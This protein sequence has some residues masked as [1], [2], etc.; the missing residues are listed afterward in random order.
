MRTLAYCSLPAYLFLLVMP[1]A[2]PLLAG[3]WPAYKAD[4]ARSSVTRDKITFPIQNVWG[5]EPLQAPRP[6]WPEPGKELHRLDF[7]Y[8]P[9]PVIAGGHVYFASSADD[10]VRALDASSGKTKWHFTTAGPVRFAPAVAG[11]KVYVASDDG[12]LYCLD[13]VS[14]KLTW[15]FRGAPDPDQVLGNGRMVSRWPLRG[16]VL[17]DD[18][19][20][21][22]AAGM[23]PSH[24]IYVYALDAVTGKVKWLNDSSGS[25]YID[26]PH[27]GASAFTGVAPQG[28]LLATKDVLMVPTGRSVPA[29]YDR[30]TGRFMYY[31]PAIN[32]RNGGSWATVAGD[33]FFSQKHGG[34]PDIDIQIGESNPRPG[35]GMLA[36]SIAS[37]EKELELPDKHRVIVD[38]DVLYASGGDEIQAIDLKAWREKK[39]LT[40]CIKWSVPLGRTYCLALADTVLLAGGSGSLTAFDTGSGKQ[41]WNWEVDGQVRGLAFAS[42][43]L[44]AAT[45]K[46]RLYGFEHREIAVPA[47]SLK[48]RPSWKVG[49][50]GKQISVAE[51][52]VKSTG[53]TSGYGIVIGETD[54]RLAM[55]LATQTDLQLISVVRGAD[56]A[57]AERNRLLTTGLYGT[58]IVVHDLESPEQLPYSPY[59]ASLVVVTGNADG[60]PGKELYRVLRPCGGVMVFPGLKSSAAK[61][62][63]K[64]AGIPR[65]ETSSSGGWTIVRGKLP[66]AGE[67]RHQW[68]DGG[69][70]GVSDE[71]RVRLPLDVLWFGGPG[72]DRMMSRHWGTSTPLSVD[73][74]VFITGQHHLITID[75]YTGRELWVSE[76]SGAGRKGA[77][78]NSAN[79]VADDDSLYV[80][81]GSSCH[82]LSQATGKTEAVYGTPETLEES[83]A[84][85]PVSQA[86]DVVWPRSWHIVGPL[87]KDSPP[88]DAEQ[89]KTMPKQ[90]AV[91]GKTY[92]AASLESVKGFLDFSNLY[93]G[94]GFAP[95]KPGEK[96]GPYP[97]PGMRRD[98]DS[99]GR[100]LYA[101]ARIECPTD[102]RLTIGAGADWWMQWH[103]DGKPIYDTLARGNRS[104]PFTVTN[105][106][107][108]TEV[109]AGEH[110]LSVM[111][112]AGSNSWCMISAGGAEYEPYLRSAPSGPTSAWGYLSVTDDLILGSYETTKSAGRVV[113]S[114]FALNKDDGDLRWVWRASRAIYNTGIAFG[115]GRLFILNATPRHEIDQAKRRGEEPKIEQT[116]VALDLAK[117][118]ELWQRDD[119]PRTGFQVQY[120]K[121]LVVVNAGAAYSGRSGKKRWQRQIVPARM[122]VIRD[123]W[124]ITQPY[125]L[126]LRTGKSRMTED[127]VTGEERPWQFA[128]AYGC[129]PVIG[130]QNLLLFRSGAAGFFDFNNDGTTNFGGIR[131]N[132]S[133]NMI[134]ANGVMVAAE[135]SSGCT[136][137]YNY[138]TSFALVPGTAKRDTWY[139]FHG[140]KIATPLKRFS[141]NLGAPGDRRDE[142]GVAWLGY[143]RPSMPGACGVPLSVIAGKQA[144]YSRPTGTVD[145][146]GTGRPWVYSSGLRGEGKVY[147]DLMPSRPVVVS[148]CATPP[149]IDGKLDD[150]CWQEAQPVPFQNNSHLA[151]P[152]TTL[153]IRRD[154]QAIYFGYRRKAAIR[155][156][157][158]IPFK[159]TLA[160][161]DA[162]VWRDDDFEIFLTDSKRQ[163]GLQFA[164]GCGG[165]RFESL[166]AIPKRDWSDLKWKAPWTHAVSK[167]ADEWIAEVAI[168][169]ATLTA[170]KL[171]PANLQLNVMSY[172]VSNPGRRSIFITDPSPLGFGR[173]QNFIPI[174]AKPVEPPQRVFTVRMHFADPDGAAPGKRLFD[175]LLQGKPVL[176]NFDISKEAGGTGSPVIKDFKGVKAKAALTIELR[177][178]TAEVTDAT[179][180][181]ICGLELSAEE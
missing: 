42:G 116:L 146:T 176:E 40:G 17:V 67:W 82:R 157:E 7:D 1:A 135:G 148:I 72:P 30:H 76:L 139:V 32:L 136:C 126:D 26:L 55:A 9:Q 24:G 129:G 19:T 165:G 81:I 177:P 109:T 143:P 97:R 20:V 151:E 74:R 119:V 159:A 140:Q 53:V 169:I 49:F 18:G 122:P 80:T 52:I 4:A 94:Y 95:L 11:G 21:F 62:L 54:S 57:E 84:A 106:V 66:D 70:T 59:F 120:A 168:P 124:I 104:H 15:K 113:T 144:W 163:V 107:F 137:S 179:A 29:A 153:L 147:V 88:I 50:S 99:V 123:D 103:L 155:D 28:Y 23:W 38:R 141:V 61:R 85:T 180:P 156:G 86:V 111:V 158:P 65:S 64:K 145:A 128:R 14:G 41:I 138:Q 16:G 77:V 51:S 48:E 131:P 181:V 47:L 3:D 173:C 83:D 117:G 46:G 34:G 5:Y 121:G 171:D 166:N 69:R 10:T 25:M 164:V 90:L 175:V 63:M 44:V 73:G 68:A 110:V 150:A 154:G 27:P 115:D 89:L 134:P 172:N 6:A 91:A 75:A 114:L 92:E 133:V 162:E 98:D 105:H 12:W 43:H 96:P 167:G 22:L 100:T 108:S 58:R 33:L 174:A 13:A 161:D 71:G 112:K 132:C 31:E 36:F 125:A 2:S 93:G 130:S 149:A 60:L 8:A 37:C 35:D 87:P 78:W 170:E 127:I 178:R 142:Q 118:T 79:F 152:Q 102:G 45:E 160:D 56:I 39:D 101:F